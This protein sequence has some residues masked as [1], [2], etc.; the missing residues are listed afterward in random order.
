LASKDELL[1]LSTVAQFLHITIPGVSKLI[2]KEIAE[3]KKHA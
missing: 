3:R 1:P 2:R